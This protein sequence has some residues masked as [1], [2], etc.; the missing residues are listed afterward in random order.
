MPANTKNE[1]KLKDGYKW[2]VYITDWTG[3]RYKID[4]S[5]IKMY[6]KYLEVKNVDF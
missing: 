2:I 3:K 1:L 5:K 4:K 6:V